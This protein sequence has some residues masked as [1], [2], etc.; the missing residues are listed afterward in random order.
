MSGNKLEKAMFGAGCFWGVEETFRKV[1]GVKETTVGYSGGETQNPTYRQ[2]CDGQTGHTEVVLVEFE[3]SALSYDDLLKVFWDCHNPTLVNRQG[4]DVGWQY[5]SVI[6]YFTPEQQTIAEAQ[7]EA[8]ELSG[9]Y[10]DPIATAIEPAGPFYRAEEYH[11]RYLLKKG[12]DFC[13]G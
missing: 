11:Q 9:E 1:P 10:S 13:G 3:P 4:P 6:F 8:L 7:R 5:R 2:V 12:A